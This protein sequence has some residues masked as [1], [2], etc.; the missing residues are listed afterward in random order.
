[1][2][3]VDR[4]KL[5]QQQFFFP[6]A[7]PMTPFPRILHSVLAKAVEGSY[8]FMS[9]LDEVRVQR[10]IVTTMISIQTWQLKQ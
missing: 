2:N 10:R 7:A 9:Q 1:M 5:K 3:R 4:N 6:F 8:F